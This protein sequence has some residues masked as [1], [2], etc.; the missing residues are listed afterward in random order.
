MNT[1]NTNIDS[2]WLK[3]PPDSF[4]I[5]VI[6]VQ[7]RPM[8]LVNYQNPFITDGFSDFFIITD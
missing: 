5:F 6:E 4:L 2:V 1:S 3:S 7:V 8:S